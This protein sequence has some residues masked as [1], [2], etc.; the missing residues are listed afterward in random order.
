MEQAANGENDSCLNSLDFA[1]FRQ[2][3]SYLYDEDKDRVL[4][5]IDRRIGAFQNASLGSSSQRT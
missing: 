1:R 5:I 4:W 2:L 3:N